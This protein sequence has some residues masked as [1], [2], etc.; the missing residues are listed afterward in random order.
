MIAQL[1]EDGSRHQSLS[2]IRGG[3]VYQTK[4]TQMVYLHWPS[5]TLLKAFKVPFGVTI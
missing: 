2:A 5:L 3:S 4:S 1:H